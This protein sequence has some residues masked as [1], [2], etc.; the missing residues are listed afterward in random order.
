[1]V[2]VILGV[3][4]AVALPKFIDLSNEAGEASDKAVVAN[5]TNSSQI[6]F[7]AKKREA[8]RL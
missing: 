4:A 5:L 8:L 2:I 7:A 1:M 3:L 6:N